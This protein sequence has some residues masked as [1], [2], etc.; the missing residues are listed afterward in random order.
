MYYWNWMRGSGVGFLEKGPVIEDREQR[1]HYEFC[2]DLGI[3]KIYR[4]IFSYQPKFALF[5]AVDEDVHE[6]RGLSWSI[7]RDSKEMII[8]TNVRLEKFTKQNAELLM[9]K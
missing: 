2:G 5:K 7:G 1:M 3:K 6:G 9:N 4:Q 8:P